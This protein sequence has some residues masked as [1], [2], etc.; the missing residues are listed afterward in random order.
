M[1]K[2]EKRLQRQSFRISHAFRATLGVHQVDLHKS[3]YFKELRVL[4]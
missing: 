4:K 3:N 2:L 1:Y